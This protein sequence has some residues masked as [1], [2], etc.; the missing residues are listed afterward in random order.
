MID[1][2]K[3]AIVERGIDYVVV[4]TLGI[5]FKIIVPASTLRELPNTNDIIKLYTYLHVK[6]D[7]FQ[8]YG[9]LTINEMEIF[10]KLIA[11]NGVGPKAAVSIL[12]TIT[13][14]N[15]YN[16]IKTGDSSVIEKSPGI[17]KKTA[18]RIILELKDK[19]FINNAESVKI[20][21]ASE[22]VLNALLSLGYTRQESISAL[23][24][25]DCTDTEN[26]LRE[27]LKKLMK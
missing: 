3:G 6:E 1:Y 14:D 19:L 26:A 20:D 5:G 23:Y 27:A 17:G 9:F 10:K 25:I 11:V 21:D 22:D 13:I 12:S 4:E 16:A 2:I 15:L 7:G 8:L 24:G 18:Q